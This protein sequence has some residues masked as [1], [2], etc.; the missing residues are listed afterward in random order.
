[1]GK[2]PI[3]YIFFQYIKNIIYIYISFLNQNFSQ[4]GFNRRGQGNLEINRNSLWGFNIDP[5]FCVRTQ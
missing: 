3:E 4:G 1:M 5:F 2:P